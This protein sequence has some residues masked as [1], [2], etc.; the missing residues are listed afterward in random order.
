MMDQQILD[1][2]KDY[3]HIE[4]GVGEIVAV[5]RKYADGHIGI[6]KFNDLVELREFAKSWIGLCKTELAKPLTDDQTHSVNIELHFI[7]LILDFIEKNI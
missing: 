4:T 7:S 2:I 1:T 5:Y 3:M 6:D